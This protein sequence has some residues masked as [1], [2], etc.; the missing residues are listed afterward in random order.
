MRVTA[1]RI[2]SLEVFNVSLNVLKVNSPK[3]G[4][5]AQR[6]KDTVL[7]IFIYFKNTD[8]LLHQSQTQ[9]LVKEE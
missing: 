5:Q 2:D 9:T 1:V 8:I 4:K 3:E 6:K 7:F